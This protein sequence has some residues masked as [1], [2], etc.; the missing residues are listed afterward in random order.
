MKLEIIFNSF[1]FAVN[2]CGIFMDDTN[3]LSKCRLTDLEACDINEAC[4][5]K[6]PQNKEWGDCICKKGYHIEYDVSY[7]I[8]NIQTRVLFK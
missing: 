3:I 2:Q 8:S 1:I 7:K 6:D 4:V 5:Q